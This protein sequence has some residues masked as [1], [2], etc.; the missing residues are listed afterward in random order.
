[1]QTV[2]TA[3]EEDVFKAADELKIS[4]MDVWIEF[5]G[6]VDQLRRHNQFMYDHS[7]RVGLYCYG[8]AKAFGFPELYLRFMSG[9]GHDVGKVY[10]P[11]EIL[12]KTT[13]LTDEEFEVIHTHPVH[14]YEMLKGI[15]PTTA[16]VC[17][18][19]HYYGPKHYGIDPETCINPWYEK[20]FKD[21]LC[22][23]A[24]YVSMCD[25]FDAVTTRKNSGSLVADNTDMRAVDG[26]MRKFFPGHGC[27]IQWLINHK[28]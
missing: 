12:N 27:E 22:A 18:L 23:L 3:L 1:M 4:T 28:I 9:V 14:S 13:P 11:N 26:V 20:D 15:V 21:E 2:I 25:F 19:H 10:V 17:G 7:L 24:K 16:I 8:L 5:F 6:V